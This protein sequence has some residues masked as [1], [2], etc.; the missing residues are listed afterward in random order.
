MVWGTICALN[1]AYF[2]LP[3]FSIAT[4]ITCYCDF[5]IPTYLPT[6][7]PITMFTDAFWVQVFRI[8]D[9]FF[10][11]NSSFAKNLNFM[12]F[13]GEFS[14]T[15]KKLP[16]VYK[17]WQKMISLEKWKFLKPC[18]GSNLNTVALFTVQTLLQPTFY[19]Q[20]IERLSH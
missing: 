17:S 19:S 10:D 14:V 12:H 18:A 15:S 11:E 7:Q 16:N 13:A 8:S 1:F 6:Y 5:Y 9:L 3:L 2:R 4:F 20:G